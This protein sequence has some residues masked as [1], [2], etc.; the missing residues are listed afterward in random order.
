MEFI[1]NLVICQEPGH[2]FVNMQDAEKEAVSI[3]PDLGP[4]RALLAF[5]GNPGS[6]QTVI[7]HAGL[8]TAPRWVVLR[9]HVV[10]SDDDPSRSFPCEKA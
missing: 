4:R 10:R 5:L 7:S 3:L 2:G 6:E 8:E 9:S 1:S